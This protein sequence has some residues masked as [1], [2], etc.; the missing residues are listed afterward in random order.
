[1]RAQTDRQTATNDLADSAQ[2]IAFPLDRVDARDHRALRLTIQR[3]Q[4][5]FVGHRIDVG[6]QRIRHGNIDSAQVHQVTSDLHIEL[7]EQALADRPRGHAGRGLS[8]RGTLENV[9]GVVTVVLEYPREI[10]VTGPHAGDRTSP[11][12]GIALAR[13]RVHDVLPILPVA[14]RDQHRD[15]RSNGLPRAHTG[16]KLD[17]VALDLH[18]TPPPIPLLPS[19]QLDVHVLGEQWQSRGHSFQHADQGGSV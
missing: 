4:R 18:A 6:R 9:A 11:R 2:R 3:S 8:C 12:I 15:R 14:V 13:R 16:Q 1:M 17:R 19:R 7:G 5:R 10:G